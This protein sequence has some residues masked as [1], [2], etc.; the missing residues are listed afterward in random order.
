[1]QKIKDLLYSKTTEA[2]LLL[3]AVPLAWLGARFGGWLEQNILSGITPQAAVRS[4]GTLLVL[5]LYS[6]A[7]ILVLQFRLSNRRRVVIWN[8]I[9]FVRGKNRAWSP[10][11]PNCHVPIGLSDVHKTF[12]SCPAN[13]GWR[14]GDH[15]SSKDVIDF[16][17][18]LR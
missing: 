7:Y 12:I 17:E 8:G 6:I 15:L 1:M 9:E 4:A 16:I 2:I 10:C 18:M 5:L 3:A 14:A 11:C 13:C